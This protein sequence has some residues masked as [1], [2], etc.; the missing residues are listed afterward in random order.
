MS[1]GHVCVKDRVDLPQYQI[2]NHRVA[3]HIECFSQKICIL[4]PPLQKDKVA[5]HRDTG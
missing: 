3:Y 4:A 1:Y 5:L 2:R